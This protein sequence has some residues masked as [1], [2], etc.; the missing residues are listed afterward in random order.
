MKPIKH[1]LLL[2]A[3]VIFSLSFTAV[4]VREIDNHANQS[5]EYAD[6]LLN[7]TETP[8]QA[9][10]TISQAEAQTIALTALQ[11]A[12]AIKGGQLIPGVPN[13]VLQLF[14]GTLIGLIYAAIHRHREK[15]KL[16]KAGVLVD[17]KE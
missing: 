10:F 13:G 8:T 15:K 11:T 2:F 9:P 12:E 16:R 7:A 1:L 4:Q 14:S 17:Q 3:Y 6:S 5:I